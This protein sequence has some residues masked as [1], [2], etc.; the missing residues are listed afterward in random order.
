MTD[1]MLIALGAAVTGLVTG[2]AITLIALLERPKHFTMV[3][4][5]PE[6]LRE[7]LRR[8]AKARKRAGAAKPKKLLHGLHVA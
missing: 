3:V 8:A 1:H 5:L 7:K 2:A 6:E 4:R